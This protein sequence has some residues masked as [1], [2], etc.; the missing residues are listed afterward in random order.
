MPTANHGLRPELKLRDLVLMQVLLVVGLNLTGYASKQGPSQVVLWLLA[1]FLFYL[2]L[3]AVV[4]KLSRAIPRE[5][6]VYQWVKEGVS[7]FAGYMAGWSLTI[8]AI[9]FFASTGSQLANGIA[10]VYGSGGAWIATSQAF[11]LTLT[12]L[13]CLLA[14]ILNVLG[15]KIAKWLSA[16]GSLLSIATFLVLLYLLIRVLL[17][18]GPSAYGSLSLAWPAFSILTLNVFTK[19]ALFAL[20]GFDQCAIFSEEC[21]KPKNDVAR[22]VLLAA[23]LIALMYILGTC[24]IV[25]YI[26]PAD[27]DVAAP[28]SQVMQA[29]FGGTGFGRALAAIVVAGFSISLIAAVVVVVGMVSRLPMAAGWDGLLPEWWSEL[30]PRFRTPSKAIG[31]VTASLMLLGVLS[32]L[33]AG[34][35]EAVQVLSAAGF[36]SYC[37]MYMLLFGPVAF[38][39][40]SHAWRPGVG[41]RLGAL[42]AF[43][44]V[45]VAVIFDLIP[46][47]EVVS[48]ARFAIKVAGTIC[49]ANGLGAFLYW[50]GTRRL[51]RMAAV[52][53]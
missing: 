24:S 34:N 51:Q 43:M 32:L 17:I 7:P 1:I 52:A 42:A 36:G 30:H 38:G 18:T 49:A 25:A 28:V 44:V 11:T 40:R 21:R 26:V 20:S 33:G 15:L 53:G 50:S 12:I 45:V 23:P 48:P 46:L 4:M 29:G 31:V 8:W 41:V 3:A 5:G 14:F 19:M 22:S 35:Q 27:V 6:G 9:I 37:V 2:P 10:H 13:I 39:F 47:G 16:V